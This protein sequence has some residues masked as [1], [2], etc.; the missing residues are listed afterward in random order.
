MKP[1]I[2]ILT[3]FGTQDPFVGIMK[4][5]ITNI[6]PDAQIIDLS[7]EIPPGDVFRASIFLWQSISYFPSGSVFL[8]VVDPGVGTNRRPIILN[9]K[10]RIFI[11]PDNGV[12]TFVSEN[13]AQA[14]RLDNPGFQLPHPMTTFHG[15][16]IFAPAAAYAA[17]GTQGPSFGAKIKNLIKIPAPRLDSTTP[18]VIIGETLHSDRFGN[19]LTSL[20]DFKP[21]NDCI[22]IYRSWLEDTD[23]VEI[24]M[25]N[26]Q[27]QISK[28]GKI[29]WVSTFAEIPKGKYAFI[30]GSS[31]LIEIVANRKKAVT[32]LGLEPGTILKFYFS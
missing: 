7:H 12:F 26:T 1:T 9:S 11:G 25:E 20:G 4:G 2:V 10:G 30:V 19:V 23:P 15:R 22:Y 17:T 27:L 32:I 18:G 24:N 6:H 3:D 5:V 31:G 14:W 8:V 13:E 16:D 29:K 28:K 21:I